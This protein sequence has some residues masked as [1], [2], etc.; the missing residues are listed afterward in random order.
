[1]TKRK[2]TE[3]LAKAP[4]SVFSC[5]GQAVAFAALALKIDGTVT[6][7]GGGTLAGLTL[8]APWGILDRVR[9]LQASKYLLDMNPVDFYHLCALFNECYPQKTA[10]TPAASASGAI[11]AEAV[12]PLHR[13]SG[14]A[15]FILDGRA[16]AQKLQLQG[17]M[18][19]IANYASTNAST[20]SANVRMSGEQANMTPEQSRLYALPA[21]KTSELEAESSSADIFKT[22]T[23]HEDGELVGILLRQHDSSATGD[24][25]RVDG[26]VKRI[27]L[28]GAFAQ[29]GMLDIS[30]LRWGELKAQTRE[31]FHI[32]QD[33]LKAGIAFVPTK[34]NGQALMVRAG[35]TLSFGINT[36]DTVE[37][38]LTAVT[39]ASGDRLIVTPI[40]NKL[41]GGGLAKAA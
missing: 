12:L 10:S 24:S 33:V 40:L 26:I 7:T 23:L 11:L 9:L 5:V 2:F 19:A 15:P 18:N 41:V 30:D 31:L 21:Y 6:A 1:M 14:R 28:R 13:M 3:E 32:E 25:Q 38:E 22:V 27:M 8:D 17:A 39:P 4:S 37:G 16:D 20:F 36:S 35:D 34:K 29:H